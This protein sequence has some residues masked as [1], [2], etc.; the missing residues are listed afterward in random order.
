MFIRTKMQSIRVN[1]LIER[2]SPTTVLL[3]TTLT[4]TITQYELPKCKALRMDTAR[5]IRRKMLQSLST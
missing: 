3:R 4:R 5:V 1:G 2:Q